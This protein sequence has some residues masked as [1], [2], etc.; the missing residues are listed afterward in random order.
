MLAFSLKLSFPSMGDRTVSRPT[1]PS[2]VH[3][4]SFRPLGFGEQ[5]S[6]KLMYMGEVVKIFHIL[7]A[8]YQEKD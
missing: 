7:V 4:N 8:K 2:K 1:L 3:R 5:F 6:L